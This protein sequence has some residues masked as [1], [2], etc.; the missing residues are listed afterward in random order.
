M[1]LLRWIRWLA[2]VLCAGLASACTPGVPVTP[3]PSIP[4]SPSSPSS[5]GVPSESPTPTASMNS[6]Q[7]A[8]L[9][10]VEGYLRVSNEIGSA[11]SEYSKAKMTTVLRR[12]TGG[13]MI[14]AN[15][16]SFMSMKER[17]HRWSGAV[18]IKSSAVGK[19]TDNRDARGLETQVTACLDQSG[20]VVVDRG[21]KPVAGQTVEPF[22]LRQFSVRR[23]KGETSWRVFGMATVKGACGP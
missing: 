17:G 8:A 20:L 11:P 13:D 4:G 1:I 5:S 18:S 2:V 21:G 14:S 19:V 9:A 10:A 23:P 3:L 16:N 22:N 6:A 7:A 12:F 15:V